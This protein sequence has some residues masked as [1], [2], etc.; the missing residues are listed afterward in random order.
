[1]TES[2]KYYRTYS[3]LLS[4]VSFVPAAGFTGTATV[5]YV[6]Y[7]TAGTAY[8]GKVII[9]VGSDT[10]FTDIDDFAW[11]SDAISYLY[12][13]GIVTGSGNNQYNPAGVMSRGDFV[14]MITRAFDLT[15]G[16]DN[17]PDVPV[18]SYYY[19]AIAAAKAYGIVTGTNGKFSPAVAISRQDAMVIVKRVLDLKG[20]P[21][22]SGTAA[23]LA[24]FSDAAK[25]SDY[26]IP[27]VSSLVKAGII[28]GSGG[29]LRPKDMIS[30]AEMAVI[31]YR[32]LT[33]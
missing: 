33:L 6:G 7:T 19:D 20:I 1:V 23:S 27:A 13:S 9:N 26:A 22:I 24:R 28:N 25:V 5:S 16:T 8:I 18:G 15:G 17:F 31:F 14:L 4:S 30:R 10:P 21:I 12:R 29:M 2:G 11:A 32:V 3:P